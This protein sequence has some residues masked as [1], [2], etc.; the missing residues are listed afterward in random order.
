MSKIKIFVS[1]RRDMNSEIINNPIYC[2]VVCGSALIKNLN[3]KCADNLGDNISEKAPYYSEFTVQYWAWKNCKADYYGLCHY[4]RYLS[5]AD[6]M[7]Q[8]FNE[9]RF[10]AEQIITNKTVKKYGLLNVKKME[11]EIEKYDVITSVTYDVKNIPNTPKFNNVYECFAYSPALFTTPEIIERIKEI[12]KTNYPEYYQSLIDELK[13]SQ[14]RGFN[15]FVMRKE[16]FFRMCEFEFGTLFRLEKELNL[17]NRE[18]N[19][20]RELAYLGEIL[21]GTFIRWVINQNKYKVKE[22]QIVLF[23]NTD[24]QKQKSK[25]KTSLQIIKNIFLPNYKRLKKIEKNIK[26]QNQILKQSINKISALQA[27]IEKIKNQNAML[28]F[29]Q[30]RKFPENLD[31]MKLSFWK[32][33]PKAIGDLRTIQ[34]A[35][36]ALL[37]NF[38]LFCDELNVTFWLHGGS[39]IVG[40]RHN[41]FVPWDDDIDIAM[42]REDF[43]KVKDFLNQHSN[44]YE[45]REYYYFNLGCRSY[46]FRRKDIESA[47][48]VDIFLYDYYSLKFEDAITDWKNLCYQKKRIIQQI[49]MTCKELNQLP[50]G[51]NPLIEFPELKTKCDCIFDTYIN[52]NKS[53]DIS[54]YLLWNLDNNYENETRY[55]WHHGRIFKKEDIFPLKKCLFE[56]I[57]VFIPANYEK[58]TFAE[59]GF[60]YLDM[61]KNF[62]E[63]IH[64]QQYFSKAG[65]LELAQKIIDDAVLKG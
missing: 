48:F 45:I 60:S 22:T 24:K 7:Y 50:N 25:I 64:W 27:N 43:L 8:E 35:E 29:S 53:T 54:D 6:K 32:S 20:K 44:I 41:G 12:V 55:A 36:A 11:K 63:A 57:E 58:Y 33:F 19:R 37:K 42:L 17:K 30:P 47:V 38:A 9:Q 21:Y 13:S 14:H 34:L 26:E 59:Y 52:K 18:G 62:G 28:F 39:L 2:N 23:L 61:P 4:R 65:Q 5:F 40:L 56:N 15:C 16:L 1:H 51:N 3:G 10:V 31:E 46:R 49:N